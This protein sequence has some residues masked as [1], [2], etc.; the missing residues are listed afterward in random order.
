MGRD[1][2]LY[3]KNASKSDLVSFIKSFRNIRKSSSLW[4]WPKGTLNF[5][6][7]DSID[8]KSSVGV[9]ITIYPATDEE[10][11]YTD[12][13]WAIH[14]RNTYSATWYDVTMLNT[15]LRTGRK[16]FG[17]DIFGDYGKNK[18]APL[19][20]DSSSPMGRGLLWVRDMARNNLSSVIHR[21]PDE[22]LMP[23]GNDELAKFLGSLDPSRT[24][25]NGL[26]PFLVSI[27]EFYLKN[28]FV[29]VLKYDPEAN[30]KM[31][32]H[33][34]KIN[35]ID[36]VDDKSLETLIAENYTFQNLRQVKKAFK[37]WLDIDIENVLSRP[38]T[39][40]GSGNTLWNDLDEL[41]V[42]RHEIIH[43]LGVDSNLSRKNFIRLTKTTE[44]VLD[45]LLGYLTK[46]YDVILENDEV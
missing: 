14:V 18:Y 17:G 37:D 44:K 25:Y 7:F 22:T 32:D 4:D 3:P 26:V 16:K 5:H 27:V 38:K 23:A 15:I 11:E 42:Y 43:H 30:G 46:K 10:K 6:W 12:N 2:R 20:N 1:L 21:I 28:I 9:E 13:L 36:L 35:F 29:I 34:Q 19:W 40:I 8:Y 39:R 33:S 24:I 45:T 31:A 41:I